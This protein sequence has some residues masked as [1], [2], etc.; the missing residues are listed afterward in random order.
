MAGRQ[1]LLQCPVGQV[2]VVMIDVLAKDCRVPEP[3]PWSVT[4]IFLYLRAACCRGA[5]SGDCSYNSCL[6]CF[7]IVATCMMP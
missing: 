7:E 3:R 5:H 4:C 1:G 6:Y 2:R